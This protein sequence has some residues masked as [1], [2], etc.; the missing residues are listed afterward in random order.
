MQIKTNGMGTGRSNE[1]LPGFLWAYSRILFACV[2]SRILYYSEDCITF[3]QAL[4]VSGSL[5]QSRQ[6]ITVVNKLN[7]CES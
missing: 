4:A 7:H 2:P 1:Q 6:L 5:Y 3:V